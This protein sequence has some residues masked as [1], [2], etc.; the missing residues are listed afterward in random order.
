V[1]IQPVETVQVEQNP[2]SKALIDH[3]VAWVKLLSF[4]EAGF[5]MCASCGL[6]YPSAVSNADYDRVRFCD[7]FSQITIA[8]PR[9]CGSC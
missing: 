1:C 6:A 2:N 7:C 9:V 3:D 8:V 4:K 5:I